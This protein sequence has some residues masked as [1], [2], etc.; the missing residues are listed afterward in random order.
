MDCTFNCP[1]QQRHW[2]IKSKEKAI[3]ELI[4]MALITHCHPDQPGDRDDPGNPSHPGNPAILKPVEG[5]GFPRQDS[6]KAVL[7]QR[8]AC[9]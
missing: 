3:Q 6:P 9:S 5:G 2:Q 4:R 7:Q 1:K 8:N